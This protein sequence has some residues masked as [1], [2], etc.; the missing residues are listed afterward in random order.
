MSKIQDRDFDATQLDEYEE[1]LWQEKTPEELS[2]FE[3][4]LNMDGKSWDDLH[5][6]QSKLNLEI[7]GIDNDTK[8]YSDQAR[9]CWQSGFSNSQKKL[10]MLKQGGK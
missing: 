4:H 3:T 10:E 8:R 6:V 2:G 1:L 7:S 9:D 5:P